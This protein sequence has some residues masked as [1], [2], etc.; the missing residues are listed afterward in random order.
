M[1]RQIYI[2]I[3]FFA[4]ILIFLNIPI[5]L[6]KS[7]ITITSDKENVQIGDEIGIKVSIANTNIA[8]FTLELYFDDAKLEYISG[9]EKSNNSNGRILYTWVSGNGE[10]KQLIEAG[11]FLFKG[12]ENG[13]SNIVVIGEFYNSDGNKIE[14]ENGIKQIQIGENKEADHFEKIGESNLPDDTNLST[15]RIN[16]EGITP[17]FSPDIKE[18]YFIANKEIDNLEVTA[19]PK[20][21][22]S[23]VTIT[24]NDNLIIG[25]N[26]IDIRVESQDKTKTDIYKIYVTKTENVEKANANLETLAIR[27][28]TLNPEF[29]NNITQYKAEIA[30]DVN[31]ID[32]LAIPEKQNA[33]VKI[34]GND[35][36]K[37]GSN[38]I[39][40]TVTA[41][42]GITDKKYVLEV[43]RRNEEEEKQFEENQ[44]IEAERLA[45][46]LEET[47]NNN[48]QN[49]TEENNNKNE[50]NKE[51][52]K[53]KKDI[54]IGIWIIVGVIIIVG[55]AFYFRIKRRK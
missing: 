10:N 52:E 28:A 13:V 55:I 8:S 51:N 26:T 24:G 16:Q 27:Q 12:K 21:P 30:N 3:L 38:K 14:L 5:S 37:I 49:A 6:A 32:I 45:V 40:I 50:I 47:Q 4:M 7:G 35:E 39:E 46:I 54:H 9:P 53:L 43:Y 15:L 42:D 17:D 33:S 48:E 19:I 20:N 23:V 44:K 34:V 36:M 2:K 25:K 22:N 29:D 11:T 41:E 31:K 18:Y 1:R